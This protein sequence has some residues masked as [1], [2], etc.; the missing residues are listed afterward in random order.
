[1]FSKE[2]K[3][4]AP[5]SGWR[6]RSVCRCNLRV[7]SSTD[8]GPPLKDL[9]DIFQT[10]WIGSERDL[11]LNWWVAAT[12]PRF[13]IADLSLPQYL[14]PPASRQQEHKVGV[15]TAPGPLQPWARERFLS[16][17]QTSLSPNSAIS[18]STWVLPVPLAC[19]D[20]SEQCGI[21]GEVRV[22]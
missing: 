16:L 4:R 10:E 14:P 6:R 20:N 21:Y 17:V 1:M 9:G 3:T 2:L 7:T 11:V 8:R 13:K 18:L 12:Y 15:L 19:R 22:L 5:G